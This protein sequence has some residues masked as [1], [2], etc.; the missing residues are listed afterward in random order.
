MPAIGNIQKYQ[1]IAEATPNDGAG[2]RL[3][4]LDYPR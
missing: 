1:T 4:A 3:M 2:L